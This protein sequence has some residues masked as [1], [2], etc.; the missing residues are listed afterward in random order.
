MYL[1][2][3]NISPHEQALVVSGEV[4]KM[5][6]NRKNPILSNCMPGLDGSTFFLE[7]LDFFKTEGA[8][9][10]QQISKTQ[11]IITKQMRRE[12]AVIQTLRVIFLA[13]KKLVTTPKQRL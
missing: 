9:E 3:P 8:T 11:H 13:G 6:F 1:Q 2:T 5:P 10:N 12:A 4:K 7:S